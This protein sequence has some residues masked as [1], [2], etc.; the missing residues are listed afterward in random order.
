MAKISKEQYKNRITIFKSNEK[1]QKK[2]K[3]YMC[4]SECVCVCACLYG[5]WG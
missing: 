2:V 5:L 3:Y 1:V 4:V